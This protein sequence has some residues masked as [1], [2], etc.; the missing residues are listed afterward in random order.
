M[1]NILLL[2]SL[3]NQINATIF[4]TNDTCLHITIWKKNSKLSWMVTG[5][6]F[7][8]HYIWF[9]KKKIMFFEKLLNHNCSN[10]NYGRHPTH[11]S[12]WMST[13]TWTFLKMQ[14][15]KINKSERKLTY[16]FQMQKVSCHNWMSNYLWLG[17]DVWNKLFK[18]EKQYPYLW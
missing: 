12:L 14:L 2:I 17:S 4:E 13:W 1:S 15:K 16:L 7:T 18:N 10:R 6:T 11:L 8:D 3:R 9:D 5:M